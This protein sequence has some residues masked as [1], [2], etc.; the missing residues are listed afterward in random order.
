MAPA[1]RQS[2]EQ[3]EATEQQ[4]MEQVASSRWFLWKATE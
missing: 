4:S 1:A 3:Q 2:L